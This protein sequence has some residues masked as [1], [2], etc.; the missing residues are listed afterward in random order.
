MATQEK[1]EQD[2]NE[3]LYDLMEMLRNALVKQDQY[4]FISDE[5]NNSEIVYKDREAH[6]EFM[7]EYAME[8]LNQHSYFYDIEGIDK[9]KSALTQ[10]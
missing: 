7:I 8:H 10:K 4:P 1:I 9:Y 6:L 5:L 2:N 3:I